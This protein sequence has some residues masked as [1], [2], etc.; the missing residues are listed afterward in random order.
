M[1]NNCSGEKAKSAS[2]RAKGCDSFELKAGKLYLW[3]LSCGGSEG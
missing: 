2:Q 3:D 1:A